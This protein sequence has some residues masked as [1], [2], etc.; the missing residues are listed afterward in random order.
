[1]GFIHVIG[2]I[3]AIALLIWLYMHFS[4]ENFASPEEKA[5]YLIQ[6]GKDAPSFEAFHKQTNGGYNTDFYKMKSLEAQGKLTVDNLA[7][8]L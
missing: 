3:A 5:E 2:I 8:R 1:M 7:K 4:S 6:H